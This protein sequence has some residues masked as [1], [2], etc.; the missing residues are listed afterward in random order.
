MKKIIVYILVLTLS[1]F[2]FTTCHKDPIDY[3]NLAVV[4][5]KVLKS[6]SSSE[7]HKKGVWESFDSQVTIEY[8]NGDSVNYNCVFTDADNNG[9]YTNDIAAGDRIYIRKGSGFKISISAKID[10]EY[11]HGDSGP[12][13]LYL[14]EDGNTIFDI[15]IQLLAGKNRIGIRVPKDEEIVGNFVIATGEIV[16]SQDSSM[17]E[18]GFICVSKSIYDSFVSDAD[19]NMQ[20]ANANPDVWTVEYDTSFYSNPS[21]KTFSVMLAGLEPNTTHYMRAF[22][23]NEVNSE[24]I[25]SRI[26][27]FNTKDR[28]ESDLIIVPNVS[29][30]T[31]S[32]NY[33]ELNGFVSMVSGNITDVESVGVCYDLNTSSSDLTINSGSEVLET[34]MSIDEDGDGKSGIISVMLENL[35]EGTEYKY[36]F[37]AKYN[38]SYYY[39]SESGFRT[40]YNPENIDISTDEPTNSVETGATAV[41]RGVI[42]DDAGYTITQKGFKY[43]FVETGG[44]QPAI[45]ELTEEVW[46]DNSSN[47]NSFSAE[48]ELPISVGTIYYAAYIKVN[49]GLYEKVDTEIKQFD[50]SPAN[51]PQINISGVVVSTTYSIKVPCEVE[52]YGRS[53]EG[54]VIW[55]VA[56]NDTSTVVFEHGDQNYDVQELSVGNVSASFN[57]EIKGL[58]LGGTYRYRPYLKIGDNEYIYG[59]AQTSTTLNLGDY[60]PKGGVIFYSGTDF[61]I[62]AFLPITGADQGAQSIEAIW[63][64]TGGLAVSADAPQSGII[65]G[66]TNTESI[67]AYHNS[68]GMTE[69]YAAKLCMDYDPQ[70]TPDIRVA[71]SIYL[72]STSEMSKLIEYING[73]DNVYQHYID[74]GIYWTSDEVDADNA[75]I[76]DYTNMTF[77]E[78]QAA[79]DADLY[80][81]IPM[82]RF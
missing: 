40:N 66:L 22:A 3:K 47:N 33:V 80:L 29:A 26:V 41:L 4:N 42:N 17:F 60:G 23:F 6:Y 46:S 71:S 69:D 21:Q 37:F 78:S 68:I 65:S 11:V 10:S 44:A 82:A 75:V 52:T 20:N 55:I 39:S 53:C 56:P 16:E 45:E 25:Y 50:V 57:A 34:S 48:I 51:L 81:C 7:V 74:E 8:E 58:T 64:Q 12:D 1:A 15:E 61:A 9:F 19:F 18:T 36:K 28:V 76:I 43:E 31:I 70:A 2:V 59:E 79:K 54:G 67:I 5:L 24:Y 13:W 14:S 72:P 77:V 63:G 49:D 73:P 38:N 30:N 32:Y 62:E 27:S 35:S